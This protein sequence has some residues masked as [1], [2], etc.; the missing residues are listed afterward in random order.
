M[1]GKLKFISL[2][3]NSLLPSPEKI[4]CDDIPACNDKAYAMYFNC[5]TMLVDTFKELFRDKFK[6]EGNRAI[7]FE[8]NDEIPVDELKQCIASSLTY[9]TRK[10]LPMLGI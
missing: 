3:A 7:V 4:G 10:H 9:H 2:Y 6:F 8:E 1:T 5:H